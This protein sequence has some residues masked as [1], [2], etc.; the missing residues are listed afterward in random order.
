MAVVVQALVP[1]IAAA[2]AFTRHPVTGRTDQILINA[3][4]GLGEAMVSG[5]ITPD[6][7]VVDKGDRTVAEF[8][9]GDSGGGP[10]LDDAALAALRRPV[11]RRSSARSA[12]RSTSR[13]PSPPMAGIS[14]RPDRS[15]P[16]EVCP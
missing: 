11:P 16:P 12:P 14:S 9:P 15:R 6:T 7:I 3:A 8:T 1:A 5:T 2:V 10:V 4:P 13:P